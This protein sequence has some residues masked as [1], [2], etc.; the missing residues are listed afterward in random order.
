MQVRRLGKLKG[1]ILTLAVIVV[2]FLLFYFG[3]FL[4][5]WQHA[6]NLRAENADSGLGFGVS[7]QQ[8][9]RLRLIFW[10][11]YGGMI[12]VA[13]ASG[14]AVGWQTR[15]PPGM[16]AFIVLP[17]VAILAFLSLGVL[18]FQNGCNV[19]RSFVLDSYC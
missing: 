1:L 17:A 14:T 13:L 18:E 6:M 10:M 12:S 19:G 7:D 9:D 5:F 2:V 8:F 4:L 3:G 16:I 11:M 15:L